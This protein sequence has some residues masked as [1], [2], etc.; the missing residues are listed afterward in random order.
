MRL[1]CMKKFLTF[2]ILLIFVCFFATSCTYRNGQKQNLI[3][4]KRRFANYVEGS[5]QSDPNR[6][7]LSEGPKLQYDQ[8]L[9][10]K[11]LDFDIKIIDPY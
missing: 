11:N 5:Q 2:I 9:G 4:S 10:P 3:Q 6:I 7:D 1:Y 8:K